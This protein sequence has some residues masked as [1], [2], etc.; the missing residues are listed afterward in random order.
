MLENLNYET[1]TIKTKVNVKEMRNK[2]KREIE[3]A[4]LYISFQSQGH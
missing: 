2:R 4:R 3:S 1:L